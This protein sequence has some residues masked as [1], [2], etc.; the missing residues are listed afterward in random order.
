MTKYS[1]KDIYNYLSTSGFTQH[2]RIKRLFFVNYHSYDICPSF[3]CSIKRRRNRVRI[4]GAFGLY[5]KEFEQL[6]SARH[7]SLSKLE[8]KLPLVMLIDNYSNI[9]DEIVFN[10][11]DDAVDLTKSASAIYD[12]CTLFPSSEVEFAKILETKEM[13]G[14]PFSSYLHIFDYNSDDSHLLRK[15]IGFVEWYICRWPKQADLLYDCLA[16]LQLR[17]LYHFRKTRLR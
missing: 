3:L 10:Y 4:G 6:W 8:F 17:R 1:E 14:K 9:V 7:S 5:F 16:P 13:V 11:T 2:D 15:S 12:L